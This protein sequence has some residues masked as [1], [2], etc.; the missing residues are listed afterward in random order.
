MRET[1]DSALDSNLVIRQFKVKIPVTLNNSNAYDTC[2]H[3]NEEPVAG[4]FYSDLILDIDISRV[5]TILTGQFWQTTIE[6]L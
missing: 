6:P 5:S 2:C 1:L 4:F 3:E